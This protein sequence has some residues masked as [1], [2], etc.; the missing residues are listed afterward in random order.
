MRIA[1]QALT[2]TFKGYASYDDRLDLFGGLDTK[3][4]LGNYR[5]AFGQGLVM[6]NTDFFLPRKTGY[7]WNKRPQTIFGDLSRT[8]EFMLRGAALEVGA[9]RLRGIG[10]ISHDKKDAVM[11]A[12]DLEG[13]R[14]INRY[15]V[16]TPRF[17][18]EVLDETITVRFA[19]GADE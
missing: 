16:M 3:I 12:P 6:D 9:G 13:N 8:N 15:I 11:N 17:E 10:F 19:V 7:G 1:E 2:E 18:Q 4:V 14:S 5:V